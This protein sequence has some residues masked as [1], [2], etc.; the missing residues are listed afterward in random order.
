MKHSSA[1]GTGYTII[2]DYHT[3]SILAQLKTWFAHS[4]ICL[5]YEL[6]A[7]QVPGGHL[8]TWLLSAPKIKPQSATFSPTIR[9]TVMAFT[10]LISH[11]YKGEKQC[12]IPTLLTILP[13]IIPNLSLETWQVKGLLFISDLYSNNLLKPY[14]SLQESF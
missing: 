5:W 10:D 7:L 11:A 9:A 3:S 12:K 13:L 4:P 6:E 8:S 1:G 14:N 2:K